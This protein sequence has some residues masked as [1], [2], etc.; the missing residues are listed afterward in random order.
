MSKAADVSKF[1][2][3]EQRSAARQLPNT[4]CQFT[5]SFSLL[6]TLYKSILLS[7]F[8]SLQP[9]LQMDPALTPLCKRRRSN[10]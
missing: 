3:G 5:V 4:C 2:S 9:T 6:D 8:T 1:E 7:K 10:L